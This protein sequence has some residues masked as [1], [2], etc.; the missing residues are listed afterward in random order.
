[1]SLST[2][3][4]AAGAGTRMKSKKP[5]VAHEIFGKPLVRYA[6]DSAKGAGAERIVCVVGFE[7]E[8]I[9]PLCEGC[10]TCV[11]E[12][13]LGTG[14][15]VNAARELFEGATGSV[16]VT[17]ADCPLVTP[18]TLKK[19]VEARESSNSAVSVLTTEFDDPTG[20]GRIV[21]DESGNIVRNVEEKDCTDEQ[22]KIKECNTGFYCFDV[23]TLFDALSKVTNDNAQGEY[24]LTDT[25]EILSN[26]G[27]KVTSV[28]AEDKTELLGVNSRVQLS[29]ATKIMQHRINKKHMEAGVTMWDEASTIIGPDVEIASDVEIWPNTMLLGTTKIGGDSVVGPNTRLTNTEVGQG[30]RVDETIAV[31]SFIDD[32]ATTGPRC[33]LRPGAH[34]CKNSKA[35]TCVEIKKSTVGEGSKVPHLSY[36]GDTTIGTGVNL[37]AGTITCNYDGVN[38]H[39]TE[40]GNDT[41]VG[42]STMLVAPVKL[43]DNVVVAAGSV[44]TEEVPDD[45]LAFGRARQTNKVD[46]F[47]E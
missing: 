42:S 10:D 47:K 44:I 31:D 23:E 33:Y 46:R 16:I 38:K 18:E 27:K 35:G 43:G 4:L 13:R 40:I 32:G 8:Q 15:A 3:I 9:E 22:R 17:Y 26:E 24:Y 6:I 2:I 19:L 12:N 1:M 29:E 34:L 5:K 41:F 28:S 14:D 37:G 11:Q 25:L 30:C 45:S 21:R 20:Y 39:K 36:I 7:R